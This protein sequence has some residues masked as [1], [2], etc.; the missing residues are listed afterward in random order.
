MQALSQEATK[1][2]L[3]LIKEAEKNEGNAKIENNDAFMPVFVE[4]VESFIYGMVKAVSYSVAHYGEQNGDLM[5]DPEMTFI[6][7]EELEMVIPSSFK[8]DY[9]GSNRISIFQGADKVWKID[10][11]GQADQ[12][13]FAEDWLNNIK[14]QQKI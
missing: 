2:F 10:L 13:L 7:V 11:K 1:I 12:T 3:T 5:A 4:R 14:A 8:N 6:F 9:A